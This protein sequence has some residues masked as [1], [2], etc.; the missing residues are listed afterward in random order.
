MGDNDKLV[1]NGREIA[2]SAYDYLGEFKEGLATAKKD[3]KMFHVDK[4]GRPAYPLRYD[5]VGYFENGSAPAQKNKKY[6]H[7]DKNGIP[8][9][10][11]SFDHVAS[12][13]QDGTALVLLEGEK[14]R[15]DKEGRKIRNNNF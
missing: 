5:W 10:D 11:E 2:F 14:F 13:M 6:F 4:E 8:L 1:E 12:F 9:Y 15:I 3:S 7:I